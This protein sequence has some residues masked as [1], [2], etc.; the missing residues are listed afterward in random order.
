MTIIL[1]S[2]GSLSIFISELILSDS[3]MNNNLLTSIFQTISASSTTGFNSVDIGLYNRTTLLVIILLMF[4]GTAPASTGGG[5][6]STT[7]GIIWLAMLSNLKGKK[8]TNV[9]Q[10]KI[11]DGIMKTAYSIGIFS[12]LLI[13]FDLSILLLIE[14]KSFMK[15]LFEVVSAFGTVGLSTGITAELKTFSKLI[16]IF[17]MFFGRLGPLAI[18]STL[19]GKSEPVHYTYS[20]GEFYLG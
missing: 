20:E 18:G 11:P 10:K 7:F 4:I 5:I 14:D 13:L 15:L 6:K 8:D 17:T 19:L 12:F 3:N 1:I 16:L 2:F 9:F